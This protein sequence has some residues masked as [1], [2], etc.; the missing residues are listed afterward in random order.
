MSVSSAI[1]P[2]LRLDDQAK[3]AAEA[4][5]KM[6]NLDVDVVKQLDHGC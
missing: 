2:T 6:L 1:T 3:E 4:I 5:N